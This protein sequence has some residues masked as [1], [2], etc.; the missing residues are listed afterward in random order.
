MG[1]NTSRGGN[2]NEQ[3][4]PWSSSF[5]R[6]RRPITGT[7][8]RPYDPW[9]L[10]EERIRTGPFNVER[11]P[12]HP[13]SPLQWANVED[14][15]MF[16]RQGDPRM[17][18][19]LRAFVIASPLH[20]FNN[21]SRGLTPAEV[22][23]AMKKLKKEIYWPPKKSKE[24]GCWDEK[25]CHHTSCSICLDEFA[26]RQQLLR[27]PC[28]HRF[29]SDCLMPWIKSHALCPVCRFDILGRPPANSDDHAAAGTPINDHAAAAEIPID[30]MLVRAM[31]EAFDWV[32]S[33]RR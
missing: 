22:D 7:Q 17:S 8:T 32:S 30:D 20:R 29:H 13:F 24:R 23:T 33:H 28:N 9:E 31:E 15:Q 11:L 14:D 6:G 19:A 5:D 21:S 27:L 10:F 2:R 3:G 26:P 16:W 1:Q 12:V 18:P 25:D 4:V